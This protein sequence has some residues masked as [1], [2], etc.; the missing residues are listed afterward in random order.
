[1]SHQHE[2][3]IATLRTHA[4]HL[5]DLYY[6]KQGRTLK[7]LQLSRELAGELLLMHDEGQLDLTSWDAAR[8][9]TEAWMGHAID[10][11]NS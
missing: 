2:L 10:E 7:L 8:H 6:M 9:L 11:E 1:M 4:L 3:D 5:D